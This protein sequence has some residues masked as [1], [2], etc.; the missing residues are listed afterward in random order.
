MLII[1][2]GA[3]ISHS[4]SATTETTMTTVPATIQCEENQ[5]YCWPRSRTICMLV[6]PTV[7]RTIPCQSTLVIPRRR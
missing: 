3:R 7:S 5:S 4:T 1:G 2:S 6:S